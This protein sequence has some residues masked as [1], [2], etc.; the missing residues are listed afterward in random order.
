MSA[1]GVAGSTID[2]GERTPEEG[3]GVAVE[4]EQRAEE[5]RRP[6]SDSHT[7]VAALVLR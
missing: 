1:A 7:P 4:Y 2:P 3:A 5:L 6:R